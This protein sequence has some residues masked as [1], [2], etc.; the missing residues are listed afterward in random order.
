MTYENV[1]HLLHLM[2][3]EVQQHAREMALKTRNVSYYLRARAHAVD[4]SFY[5]TSLSVTES[6][7]VLTYLDEK[8]VALVTNSENPAAAQ[9]NFQ[10]I[11]EGVRRR[12]EL[13][14]Q[15]RA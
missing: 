13:N 1:Q 8:E 10:N 2:V 9:K 12:A 6:L 4:I 11:F 5:D 7:D 14:L 15:T 3:S